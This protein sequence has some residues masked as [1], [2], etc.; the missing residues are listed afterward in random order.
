MNA[1]LPSPTESKEPAA[2]V[3]PAPRTTPPP[4]AEKAP[5]SRSETI[6]PGTNA[7]SAPPQ[8]AG[9]ASID[10]QEALRALIFL[11]DF[12][13]QGIERLA[14]EQP[15][16]AHP[17]ASFPAPQPPEPPAPIKARPFTPRSELP[18]VN[19]GRSEIEPARQGF[20]RLHFSCP[21]CRRRVVVVKSLA[22][23][24]I[25]CPRCFS[26]LR[27]ADPRHGVE[28]RNMEK[29]VLAISHPEVFRHV[30]GRPLPRWLLPVVERPLLILALACMVP[31][32]LALFLG[33]C[34][35]IANRNSLNQQGGVAAVRPELPPSQLAN[36][37]EQAVALVKK[38]LAAPDAVAKAAYV[39]NPDR[40]QP[41]MEQYFADHPLENR[42][43]ASCS[44]R[45]SGLSHYTDS[46]VAVPVTPVAVES[47]LGG[48]AQVF[49]VEHRA[50]GPVIEWESSVGFNDRESFSARPEGGKSMVLRVEAVVDDY[51][52]HGYA[53]A[54][55]WVCLRLRLAD[56]PDET[57]YAYVDRRS[58]LCGT[59]G[60]LW[61]ERPDQSVRRLTVE[62][63]SDGATAKTR[64]VRL[65]GLVSP[66]WR[67]PD[68]PVLRIAS[69][70]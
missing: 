61:M 35:I 45:A 41:L 49:M 21:C 6:G 54:A 2:A 20:R 9:A 48:V 23:K 29:D 52:N 50:D 37:R 14:R 64:Q 27:A 12:F 36:A 11:R 38:Y 32:G 28:A 63:S 42:P 58:D 51:F 70:R 62:V 53:D 26:A 44:V 15:S 67:L 55:K 60:R 25:R 65:T 19:L 8:D 24:L 47:A 34:S 66:S 30:I 10:S 40:V 4:R 22:G 43:M 3:A 7:P 31:V 18:M 17:Q 33:L 16:P 1:V 68:E 46:S 13:F 57:V 69:A 59:V 5:P 56:R 39:R